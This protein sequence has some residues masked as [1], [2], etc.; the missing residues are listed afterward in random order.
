M[1]WEFTD[2]ARRTQEPSP[3]RCGKPE[4]QKL[5]AEVKANGK[6]PVG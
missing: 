3:A 5:L 6:R 2:A 4:F 1:A